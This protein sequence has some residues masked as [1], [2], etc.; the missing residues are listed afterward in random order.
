MDSG[1][2]LKL[3]SGT[4]G[5]RG[6]SKGPAEEKLLRPGPKAGESPGGRRGLLALF[7][8]GGPSRF[9]L[10][11]RRGD[12][13]GGD[14]NF[15]GRSLNEFEGHR[16]T[17]GQVLEGDALAFRDDDG[18]GADFEFADAL[19]D[20]NGDSIILAI[21]HDYFAG[22]TDRLG[23]DRSGLVG[24]IRPEDGF[25]NRDDGQQHTDKRELTRFRHSFLSRSC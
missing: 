8:F 2:S 21:D 17:S 20:F 10:A 1:G 19:V 6:Q 24:F 3:F 22:V 23:R 11:L 13:G 5:I 16:L 14:Q 4:G 18:V 12:G 9:R 7:V 25:L 15:A